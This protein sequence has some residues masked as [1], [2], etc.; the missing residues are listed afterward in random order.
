MNERLI[1]I[2]DPCDDA[3]YCS[4]CASQI[5]A[6]SQV[7]AAYYAPVHNEP[8]AWPGTETC[9]FG[10]SR[11]KPCIPKLDTVGSQHHPI[12]QLK[13][14]RTVKLSPVAF[15]PDRDSCVASTTHS[16]GTGT[17]HH[18]TWNTWAYFGEGEM[19]TQG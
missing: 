8:A 10:S 15:F 6:A 9:T 1:L 12:K 14:Q 17:C 7:E 16:I 19:P 4:A 13:V 5:G 3:E 11:T 18:T 2:S